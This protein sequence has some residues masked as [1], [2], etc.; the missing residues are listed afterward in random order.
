MGLWQLYYREP[1]ISTM[2]AEIHRER[3]P[4]GLRTSAYICV[5]LCKPIYYYISYNMVTYK[6]IHKLLYYKDFILG[7]QY[8]Q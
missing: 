3:Q 6:H 4:R 8:V 5:H 1:Y 7:L 2:V